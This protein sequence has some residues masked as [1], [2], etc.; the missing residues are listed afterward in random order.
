MSALCCGL[1]TAG[2][3]STP[4]YR[5]STRL[6]VAGRVRPA[7]RHGAAWSDAPHAPS[8]VAPQRSPSAVSVSTTRPRTRRVRSERRR[9]PDPIAACGVE[10]G[11]RIVDPVALRNF[12]VRGVSLSRIGSRSLPVLLPAPEVV[13]PAMVG[14][15]QGIARGTGDERHL[16]ADVH[17]VRSVE[18]FG[19]RAKDGRSQ[20]SEIE[21]VYKGV[22]FSG[23]R[24]R[25]ST[26]AA[27]T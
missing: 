17:V 15:E 1:V 26:R 10:R 12:V 11:H 8:P 22:G 21:T 2:A 6:D 7:G 19:V 9:V 18:V 5:I 20:G 27:V 24:Q 13:E 16:S 23:G 4:V 25:P 14:E 3:G